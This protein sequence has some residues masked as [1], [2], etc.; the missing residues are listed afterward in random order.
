[1]I[2]SGVWSGACFV[3]I[4]LLKNVFVPLA[5]PPTPKSS[6]IV[7]LNYTVAAAAANE[8]G[9]KALLSEVAISVEA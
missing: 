8:R 1:M 5:L 6:F 7:F 2:Q 3:L 9:W 4:N